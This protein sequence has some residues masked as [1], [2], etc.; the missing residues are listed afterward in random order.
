MGIKGLFGEAAKATIG[1]ILDGA[2][3]I[4]SKFKADPTKIVEAEAKLNELRIQAESKSEEL[5]VEL[6]KIAQ[7]EKEAELKDMAD[8]RNREIQ[9]STSDKAPTINKI[10]T[11]ILALLVIG[12]TF[13]L[14]YII[15]FK[16]LGAEKD[17][18]IYILGALTAIDGQI[19]SYYFGSSS[20]SK[21]KGDQLDKLIK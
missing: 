11:P 18:I 17:V 15:L 16:S 3:D 5:S 9:I 7:S 2:G 20:G 12:L 10:I 19:I 6:A 21:Q 14:F 13:V 4:I 8:S 1:T